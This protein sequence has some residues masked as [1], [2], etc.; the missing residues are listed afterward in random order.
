M[1]NETCRPGGGPVDLNVQRRHDES[2]IQRTFFSS[3]GKKHGVKTLTLY[4]P[5][6]IIDSV[7]FCSTANYIKGAINLSGMEGAIKHA[8]E[9]KK[10]VDGVTYLK[11]YGDN[12]FEASEVIC[13]ANS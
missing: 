5:N 6:G 2:R 1:Q 11:V 12:I 3:Y 13:K 9:D 7:F 8:L 4:L 10:L